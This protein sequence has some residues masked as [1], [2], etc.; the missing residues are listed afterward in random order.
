MRG[1]KEWKGKREE[2]RLGG[3]D[4]NKKG[5]KRER[6]GSLAIHISGYDTATNVP[7]SC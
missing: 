5:K 7:M 3:K 6:K 1:G 4:Y 2:E